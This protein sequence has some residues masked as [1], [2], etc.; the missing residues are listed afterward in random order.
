M[1]LIRG[2]RTAAMCVS[3]GMLFIHAT[4]YS[5]GRAAA[6]DGH[7]M[8][9][10]L[11]SLD[12]TFASALFPRLLAGAALASTCVHARRARLPA[13]V[14]PEFARVLSSDARA[15]SHRSA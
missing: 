6:S 2:R 4:D 13:L 5:R 1:R 11:G 8:H 12:F 7:S 10:R 9:H 14:T 3:D 15:A